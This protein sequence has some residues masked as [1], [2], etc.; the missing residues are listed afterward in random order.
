MEDPLIPANKKNR[1]DKRMKP[2]RHSHFKEK[3]TYEIP[4]NDDATQY[5]LREKGKHVINR[6]ILE[7]FPNGSFEVID[8]YSM[9]EAHTRR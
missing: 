6:T 2:S 3:I 9:V 7:L 1:D 4:Y 8:H 5:L